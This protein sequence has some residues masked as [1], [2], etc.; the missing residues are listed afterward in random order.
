M[1]SNPN[2]FRGLTLNLFNVDDLQID[3]VT[4]DAQG[5]VY[6]SSDDDTAVTPAEGRLIANI[7]TAVEAYLDET[8]EDEDVD[9][10]LA[11]LFFGFSNE[12]EEDIAAYERELRD[13]RSP[14][15]C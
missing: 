11:A 2:T 1:N 13:L 15:G 5:G 3:E 8:D 10:A 7:Q 9:E 12:E 4:I 14:F 6:L